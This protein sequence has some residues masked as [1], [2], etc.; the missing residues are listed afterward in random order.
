MTIKEKLNW[1]TVK[2]FSELSGYTPKAIYNKVERGIW[3]HNVHWIKAPDRRILININEF[4]N[5][6]K[7]ITV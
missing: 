1:V 4:E 5:W 7:G 2:K 3:V 6:A